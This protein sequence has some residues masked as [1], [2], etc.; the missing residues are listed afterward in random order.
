[1]GEK[2]VKGPRRVSPLFVCGTS[3]LEID[4]P[5][6]DGM[7]MCWSRTVALSL[8]EGGAASLLAGAVCRGVEMRDGLVCV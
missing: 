3:A 6:R 4:A 8:L 2:G 1:M 5:E 7:P